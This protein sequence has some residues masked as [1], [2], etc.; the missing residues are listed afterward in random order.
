MDIRSPSHNEQW[1]LSPGLFVKLC[2]RF[3]NMDDARRHRVLVK[4]M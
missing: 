4:S 3:Q 2:I 1:L